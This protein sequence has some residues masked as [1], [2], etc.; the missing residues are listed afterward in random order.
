MVDVFIAG[1]RRV[2]AEGLLVT[3][4]GRTHAQA[5]VGVHIVGADQA[6][7]QFV[8]DVIVLG[9]Q[10][11]GDVKAHRIGPVLLNHAREMFGAVIEGGV[12]ARGAAR[13]GF[14]LA[15]PRCMQ[16]LL[17]PRRQMQRRALGAELANVGR[18]RRIALHIV[19]A[20][21]VVLD[22]YAAAHPAVG[23]GGAGDVAGAIHA[24]HSQHS[25]QCL[26]WAAAKAAPQTP[27]TFVNCANINKVSH[28]L[29]S[30]LHVCHRLQRR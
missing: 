11:A 18:V 26:F 28:C 1:R 5:R 24:L 7:D 8:E 19:N 23:A 20:H 6:L 13:G 29:R 25:C 22:Q 9:H 27:E 12:P 10:L 3:G 4:H 30:A 17:R 16:A 21:A 2:H 15:Q 14:A